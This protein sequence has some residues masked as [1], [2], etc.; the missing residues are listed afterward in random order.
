MAV[1]TDLTAPLDDAVARACRLNYL[2]F[3]RELGRW[4]GPAGAVEERGGVLLWATASDFPVSLNGV[5]RLDPSTPPAAVIA[6]ADQWFADRGTGFTLNVVEGVD[7]DLR[8][9]A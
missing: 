1:P 9:A 6:A 8:A 4:S 7:D 5:A 3:C 2:E